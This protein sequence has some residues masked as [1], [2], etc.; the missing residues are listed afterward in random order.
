M[1]DESTPQPSGRRLLACSSAGGHFAQLVMVVD[2][3]PD[4]SS[5]VWLTHDETHAAQVLD[6]AGHGSDLLIPADYA[7]PRDL[8]NL[9]RNART[10]RG[11]L[12]SHD[13]D[14]AISTGAGIAVATLPMARARGVRSAYIESAT[15]TDGP[16]LSGR[17]LRRAPGVELWTQN[18]GYPDPWRLVGSVHDR[19]RPGPSR[20]PQLARVVVTTG[21]IRPY[22]FRR[23]IERLIAILPLDA[24]VLWQTGETEVG[25]LG[26]DGRGRVP[27][28]ELQEAMREADVVV[29]HAGTGT[30]VTAFELGMA[31][32]LVPRRRAHGEHVDDHQVPT[33]QNLAARGLAT[34]LEVEE[35]TFERLLHASTRTVATQSAPDLAL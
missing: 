18:P 34:H 32:V 29:A 25:D 5:V 3:I 28:G 2:R 27:A 20:R 23:L 24:D 12:R 14:L 22:G 33:A 4:I 1:V 26:I 21:T 15:R 16:S 30:A 17:L 9:A 8:K 31:P 10:A 35:L 13:F 7:A 6:A 11:V 19:F